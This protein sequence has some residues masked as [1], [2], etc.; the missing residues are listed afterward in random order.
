MIFIPEVMLEKSLPHVLRLHMLT[1]DL[2]SY[3]G[4][5]S[6]VVTYAWW[7]T[8]V[9]AKLN[10]QRGQID[11]FPCCNTLSRRTQ[12]TSFILHLDYAQRWDPLYQYPCIPSCMLL[13]I[14]SGIKATLDKNLDL[15]SMDKFWLSHSGPHV[16]FGAQLMGQQS[17]PFIDHNYIIFAD[18]MD[19]R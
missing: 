8:Y 11:D 4:Q 13:E 6:C 18:V 1:R 14:A 12:P 16:L 2:T 15:G 5:D 19:W 9:M 3:P 10:L 17:G 7:S